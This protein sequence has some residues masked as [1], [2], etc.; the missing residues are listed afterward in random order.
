MA[1]GPTLSRLEFFN[2]DHIEQ[3]DG[4]E[5]MEVRE[6]SLTVVIPTS[7]LVEFLVNGLNQTAASKDAI[8]QGMT[9]QAESIRKVLES[10]SVA[11]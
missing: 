1:I 7:A 9:A 5:P 11:K 6:Q 4:G 8:V 2:V 10:I 3:S